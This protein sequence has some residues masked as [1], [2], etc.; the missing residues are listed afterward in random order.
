MLEHAPIADC[1]CALQREWVRWSLSCVHSRCRHPRQM[2]SSGKNYNSIKT[3]I[4]VNIVNG[5][6][7][8]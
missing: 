8:C 7:L 1:L 4:Q 6:N 2:D 3:D 5:W